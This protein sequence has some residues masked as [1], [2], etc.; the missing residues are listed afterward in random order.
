M[1]WWLINLYLTG[2]FLTLQKVQEYQKPFL[3]LSIS[4]HRLRS[5]ETIISD[6]VKK[7]LTVIQSAL[8]GL[9]ND[10]KIELN[11]NVAGPRRSECDWIEEFVFDTLSTVFSIIL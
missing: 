3:R 4:R 7:I 10:Q 2:T 5:S 11:I 1:L 9:K 6:S 8:C